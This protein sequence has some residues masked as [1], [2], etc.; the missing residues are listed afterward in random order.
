MA[1]R[2]TSLS[3]SATADVDH[4]ELA[5]K[6]KANSKLWIK[7]DGKV[8]WHAVYTMFSALFVQGCFIYFFYR[9][10]LA[11]ERNGTLSG[12]IIAVTV[13]GVLFTALTTL[14]VGVHL[15]AWYLGCL[16]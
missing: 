5:I 4:K 10:S 14:W 16:W 13:F 7:S 12:L 8:D 3:S 2:E 1:D 6:K 15:I 9:V 11:Y